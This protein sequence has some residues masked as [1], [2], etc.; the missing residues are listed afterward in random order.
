MGCYFCGSLFVGEI[1]SNFLLPPLKIAA[2]IFVWW[3]Y[4]NSETLQIRDK[5]IEIVF[6]AFIVAMVVSYA[7]KVRVSESAR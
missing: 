4:K 6:I 7:I 5:S 1:I 2:A 3:D